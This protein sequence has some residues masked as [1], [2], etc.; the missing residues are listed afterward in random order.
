MSLYFT[1]SYS[2]WYPH[3]LPFFS[4]PKKKEG[5]KDIHELKTLDQLWLI[6][7]QIVVQLGVPFKQR[8]EE[9]D[10]RLDIVSAS[11]FANGVHGEH[12]CPNVHGANA[13]LRKQGT[14]RWTTAPKGRASAWISGEKEE[15]N[16]HVVPDFEFLHLSAMTLDHPFGNKRWYSVCSIALLRIGFDNHTTVDNWAMLVL[17]FGGVVGMNCMRHI[18]WQ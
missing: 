5:K 10:W 1:Y 16:L 2:K 3:H 8:F 12:R 6:N 4:N 13:D 11:S 9:V 18:A 14:Y 7:S 17:V 15:T